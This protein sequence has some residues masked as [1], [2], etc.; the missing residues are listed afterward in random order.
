MTTYRVLGYVIRPHKPVVV[1]LLSD[2]KPV[3]RTMSSKSIYRGS[4]SGHLFTYDASNYKDSRYF[5]ELFPDNVVP[6]RFI[7]KAA[8]AHY[9]QRESVIFAHHR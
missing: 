3:V 7:D 9:Q 4:D 8:I 2:D 6:M 5:R 1:A